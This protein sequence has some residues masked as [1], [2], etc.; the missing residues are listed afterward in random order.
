MAES[1]NGPKTRAAVRTDFENL[2]PGRHTITVLDDARVV[3]ETQFDVLRCITVTSIGCR[4]V[5]FANP[6][7]NPPVRIK[8]GAGM[9]ASYHDDENVDDGR[10]VT[11]R[12]GDRRT[13]ETRR[14][15]FGW[16]ASGPAPPNGRRS[17]AGE[18]YE[19][20]V[21]QYC[22]ATMTRAVVHCSTAGQAAVDLSF[23][24]PRGRQVAYKII[25]F[26][27][28]V[29]SGRAGADHRVRL[30]LPSGYYTLRAYTNAAVLPY[31]RVDFEVVP[32]LRVQVRCDSAKF[33]NSNE[34]PSYDVRVR[35]TAAGNPTVLRVKGKESKEIAVTSGSVRWKA[36][37]RL[38][39][40]PKRWDIRGG[41][42]SVRVPTDCS[43]VIR[44][45]GGSLAHTGG[46]VPWPLGG[47]A[48][49]VAGAAFLLLRSRRS[50][51][52][53]AEPVEARTLRPA[54]GDRQPDQ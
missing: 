18:D 1:S 5:T 47:S 44:D 8:S 53:L 35:T 28:V 27:E 39:E 6:A 13:V 20:E 16:S 38:E 31:E 34:Y 11:V 26:H 19:V 10:V 32:C 45:R 2:K 41:S 51:G 29:R 33:I 23:R 22:G 15:Y 14:L 25:D 3:V 30:W 46:P 21:P 43:T 7:G 37:P 40:V 17:F 48:L 36:T 50:R 12:P 24:P 49:A 52:M 4:T 42:G 54:Q 9:D